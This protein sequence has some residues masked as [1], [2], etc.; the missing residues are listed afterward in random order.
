MDN[1]QNLAGTL[2]KDKYF[3]NTFQIGHHSR[4]LL[5]KNSGLKKISSVAQYYRNPYFEGT[6][7][8]EIT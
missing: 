2:S 8:K 3:D 1:E 7:V 4:F 5:L 6:N